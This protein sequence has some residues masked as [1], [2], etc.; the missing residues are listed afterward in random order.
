MS[1]PRPVALITGASRG[2]GRAIARE[3]ASAGH[4]IVVNFASN[5]EAAA[6]TAREVEAAGGR[7]L[8]APADVASAADREALLEATREEFGRVDILVNNAALSSLR[9][10]DLLDAS[11]ESY[12]RVLDVNL[13]G[14]F[15]LTQ[16]V[17]RWMVELRGIH[18]DRRLAIVNISSLSEYAPSVNR[19]DYCLAKAGMGMLTRLFAMRLAEHRICVN[20]I[21]PGIIATDM[22]SGVKEKYDRLI[23]DG[24]TPIRRWGQ[25]E[26][27]ARAVRAFATGA[28]DFTT[29]SAIDV[30]GGFHVKSL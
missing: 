12:D 14:P 9:R 4:D 19:G 26:D 18:P 15:F 28:F 10:D 5:R 17:A 16:A 30:D 23:A 3:L 20:E 11:E 21:R 7:A 24:L 13:K 25:P 1:D 27:V 8:L 6:G 22:T 2:I 29:G